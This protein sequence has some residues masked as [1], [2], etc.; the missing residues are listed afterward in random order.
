MLT[1]SYDMCV[2][3]HRYIATFDMYVHVHRIHMRLSINRT[4]KHI[5]VMYM[6]ITTDKNSEKESNQRIASGN[7]VDEFN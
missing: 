7:Q 1:Y 5:N 6:I 2:D 4:L 3:I